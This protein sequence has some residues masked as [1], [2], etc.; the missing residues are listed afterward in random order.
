[1]HCLSFYVVVVCVCSCFGDCWLLRCVVGC[2][3]F[4]LFVG[5]FV[6]CVVD[7]SLVVRCRLLLVGSMLC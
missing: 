6:S 1:M 4:C 2:C 5:C 7:W 3:W